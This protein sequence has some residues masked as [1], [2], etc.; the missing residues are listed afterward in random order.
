MCTPTLL[1]YFQPNSRPQVLAWQDGG[2]Y[3]SVAVS[4]DVDRPPR[5]VE[6]GFRS[7]AERLQQVT[8]EEDC[9]WVARPLNLE[10]QT[11]ARKLFA[12]DIHDSLIQSY[13]SLKAQELLCLAVDKALIDQGSG[14]PRRRAADK[15][16]MAKAYIDEHGLEQISVKEVCAH[17]SISESHL[18]KKFR[19]RFG[20]TIYEY[21]VDVRMAKAYDLLSF[22]DLHL[23]QIAYEVGYNHVSNFCTAFKKKYGM[24]P[25]SVRTQQDLA[26]SSPISH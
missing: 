7:I 14:L 21:I 5:A 11:I 23:K 4:F 2:H 19:E 25:N 9:F 8:Q 1:A 10:M 24:T 20:T 12:P 3:A 26:A 16:G 17:L 22:S 15:V 6:S 18:S 13:I